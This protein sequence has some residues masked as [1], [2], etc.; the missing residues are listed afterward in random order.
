MFAAAAAML[1]ASIA[2]EAALMPVGARLFSRVTFAGLALNFAAIPL[3]AVA[4]I[5]G[6]P[7]L[8]SLPSRSRWRPRPDGWR[9]PPPG[10]VR[11]ADLVEWVPCVTWRVA[12]PHWG[13]VAVY[14]GAVLAVWFLGGPQ[15]RRP[16]C[17]GG[18]PARRPTLQGRLDPPR[19]W[20]ALPQLPGSS[21][22]RRA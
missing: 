19:C 22:S 17:H 14:Y 20:P 21:S 1:A 11:S 10:L 15:R 13:A 4:Q 9:T 5:A 16:T 12:P 7:P 18:P 8:L 6:M 3:M 2:A